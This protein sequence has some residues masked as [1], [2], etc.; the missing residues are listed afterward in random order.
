MSDRKLRR[1]RAAFASGLATL[2][3]ALGL[4]APAEAVRPIAYV[5]LGD[6]YAAGQGAGSYLDTE[7]FLSSNSYA[8]D[9]DASK[10]VRLAENAACSGATTLDVAANQLDRLNQG[11]TLVTITAGGNDINSTAVLVA[12]S[13]APSSLEC[14]NA[15]ALATGMISQVEGRLV[16]LVEAVREEAP[17]ARI[18]LTG[19]PY[20]FDPANARTPEEAAFMTAANDATTALNAAIASAAL[21]SGAEY[22]D[23]TEEFGGHAAN[24]I[25]PWINPSGPDSFH[26]N[27]AGYRAYY[28]ALA[29][30]GVYS[31]N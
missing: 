6:S 31:T 24:S 12:C 9:A 21:A 30:E 29:A 17:K 25:D 2:T 1:R 26:P 14:A 13:T 10:A 16:A 20:L 18:V 3:L 15:L 8:A 27:A 22:V 23:V 5:A 19:Y 11:I 4:A 7:C 28:E